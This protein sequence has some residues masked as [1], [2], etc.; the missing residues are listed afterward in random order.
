MVS[1]NTNIG[2]LNSRVAQLRTQ[3]SERTAMARL[4]SGLRINSAGD[5]AAGLSV[6]TKMTSQIRSM[7]MAVR[8]SMDG[9]SLVD[10]AASSIS[11][12]LNALQRIR[13]L[14]IQASNGI[15]EDQDRQ[16]L[17]IEVKKNLEEIRKTTNFTQFNG[18]NLLD[19][20]LD[21]ILR[22]GNN[23]SELINLK[24]EGV[25]IDQSVPYEKVATAESKQ[26]MTPAIEPN[27]SDDFTF[28]ETVGRE[29]SYQLF[30][31][32]L[33]YGGSRP[34]YE[35]PSYA[36]IVAGSAFSSQSA[37]TSK[38]GAFENNDFTDA[39][40]ENTTVTPFGTK[41]EIPGWD[42]YLERVD[43]GPTKAGLYRESIG[44]HAT[45]NDPTPTPMPG[46]STGDGYATNGTPT[47]AWNASA[48]GLQLKSN[49]FNFNG[50]AFTN[51]SILHGPYVISDN[52]VSLQAGDSVQFDWLATGAGDDYD[53][54]GYL[55]DK[56]TGQIIEL[57]DQNGNTGNGT[58]LKNIGVGQ[59]GDYN[60]VFIS[61]THDASGGLLA[62]A[63][64]FIDNIV[65]NQANPPPI[66]AT[67]N[68]GVEAVESSIVAIKTKEFGSLKEIF[69]GDPNGVFSISGGADAN[70]FIIDNVS[71]IVSSKHALWRRDQTTYTIDVSYLGIG[72]DQH[73]E[74][75]TLSI[76]P[77][78]RAIAEYHSEEASQITINNSASGLQDFANVYGAG[79]YSLSSDSSN[80]KDYLNFSINNSGTITSNNHLKFIEQKSFNFNKV[81]TL[82]SG[83]AFIEKIKLTLIDPIKFSRTEAT[84]EEGKRVKI[85]EGLSDHLYAFAE[86]DAYEGEFYL[87]PS[88]LSNA[89]QI[90]LFSINQRG[91]IESK[92]ELDFDYG[93]REFEFKVIYLHSA[94]RAK[95]TDF[96]KLKLK[97]DIRDENNLALDDI[98][99]SSKA[100]ASKASNRINDAINKLSSSLSKL[101][102]VKN[103]LLHGVDYNRNAILNLKT[104]K[105]RIND[106]DFAKE[107][108]NLAKNKILA[109][110]SVSMLA[111]ANAFKG[112]I[113]KLI[114]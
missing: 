100:G 27:S 54:Y 9:I 74:T 73:T 18:V 80:S 62:G 57:L 83:K 49:N 38:T 48:S 6:A 67:A 108:S 3:N 26:L 4:S 29:A 78:D 10:T 107:A 33:A 93:Q 68:V 5:D 25:G 79:T 84:S 113:L 60:F 1:V 94:G 40:V 41:V 76:T 82:A 11:T 21:T 104:S 47:Y 55:L 43:L 97:N 75:V 52:A 103:R 65:V 91:E 56:N 32:S 88:D 61:G 96:V 92:E 87:S 99:I 39:T 8:N 109:Q 22:V 77:N 14:S 53:V 7:N 35:V 59:A 34:D 89:Q 46:P 69:N 17:Q 45:P 72:G 98:D 106:A 111:Q 42:I 20:S 51:Y 63:E 24:I 114:E 58:V 15:Y 36:R 71:G 23:N 31:T 37:F 90:N 101:G 12:N 19:G 13:E 2:A 105:G 112:N 81:Y 110:A 50:P 85:A 95:Y 86:A 16:N 44:G 30:S 28:L 64:F 102:A 66:T 70:K